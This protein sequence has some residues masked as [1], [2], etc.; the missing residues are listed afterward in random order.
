MLADDRPIIC[1]DIGGS[2]IKLGVFDPKNDQFLY[3]NK[4]PRFIFSDSKIFENCLIKTCEPYYNDVSALAFACTGRIARDY[5]VDYHGPF[6]FVEKIDFLDISASVQCPAVALNDVSAAAYGELRS[7]KKGT[8]NN[9]LFVSIGTGIGAGIVIDGKLIGGEHGFAG[10]FGQNLICLP[11]RR[12]CYKLEE[13]CSGASIAADLGLEI[14]E[15]KIQ[16]PERLC[17]AAKDN[18]QFLAAAIQNVIYLLDVSTVVLGGGLTELL[19]PFYR[20]ELEKRVMDLRGQ[21][22]K[23]KK[24]R[25]GFKAGMVGIGYYAKDQLL[26]KEE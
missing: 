17:N 2:C 13:L 19:F 21:K 12:E 7:A 11:E 14:S 10:E 16:K 9:F 22:I 23:V 20:Q 5:K 15:L 24:A 6:K 26:T 8:R 3:A 18:F 4:I 1:F 25:H